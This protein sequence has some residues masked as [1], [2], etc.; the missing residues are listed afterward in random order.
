MASNS[1]DVFED[2]SSHRILSVPGVDRLFGGK[3]ILFFCC[4]LPP[5]NEID[6]TRMLQ[7]M[8][9][10]LDKH[11]EE[12]YT[13]V[14]FQHGLTWRNS[15][16]F[17]WLAQA[18]NELER[19]YKKNLKRLYI[20]HPSFLVR[21]AVALFKPFI[22]SKFYHK[23]HYIQYIKDLQHICWVDT[24]QIPEEVRRYDR[25]EML[26]Q[27]KIVPDTTRV[28]NSWQSRSS[29][30]YPDDIPP[31][32]QFGVSLQFL[33]D[34]NNGD[35]IPRVMKET[36]A[37]IRENGLTVEGVFRRSP[38][39]RMV[40]VIQ[41]QY[42]LGEHVDFDEYMDIRIPC[43]ILKMFFKELPEP[44][45]SNDLYPH[46]LS[47]YDIPDENIRV[48]ICRHLISEKIPDDNYL[49]LD[50]L[51]KLLLEVVQHS[52]KNKMSASNIAV[53]FGPNLVWS[54]GQTVSLEAP[55]AITVF[56]TT[57]LMHYHD[58][59]V[60]EIFNANSVNVDHK[61]LGEDV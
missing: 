16:S 21:I 11:V 38:N 55:R 32:Q 49:V 35:P 40:K 22:S 61:F 33:K 19:K 18:Y 6:H 9:Y 36:I 8:K 57:L 60:R 48:E 46:I 25:K 42:D 39:A 17:R 1:H 56:I 50:Y 5:S 45:L 41:K 28:P 47:I 13:L 59:F 2:I 10:T 14:I 53:V 12:D 20:V 30:S 52:D 27:G 24:L 51:M 34:N 7:Y 26:N 58:I 23:I 29:G 54:P 15:P 37:Y 4:R 43:L 3:L 44:I 31:T